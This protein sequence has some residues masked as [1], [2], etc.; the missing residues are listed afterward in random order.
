MAVQLDRTLLARAQRF[1]TEALEQIH[2]RF[3]PQIFRYISF[4]IADRQT[5][6]DLTGDVFTRLLQALHRPAGA[7]QNLEAW[8]FGV[9]A[10]VV[11]DYLRKQYRF[12]QVTLDDDLESQHLSPAELAEFTLTHEDLRNALAE[13]TLEQQHVL[14]LRFGRELPINS[15]AEMLG[16][17]IGSIK[18]LQARAIA[19]LTRKLQSRQVDE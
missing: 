6:E 18:Q 7:I 12:V 5:V 8:L 3:Y 1:E 19:S 9:A 10:H 11:A 15:V 16:K 14:A 4:R 13:L 2:D 17:T